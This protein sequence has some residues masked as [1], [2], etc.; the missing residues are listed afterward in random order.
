ML[1]VS[2]MKVDVYKML[3]FPTGRQAGIWVRISGSRNINLISTIKGT[4]KSTVI[5]SQINF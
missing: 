4:A 5:I 2:K 3:C 1:P